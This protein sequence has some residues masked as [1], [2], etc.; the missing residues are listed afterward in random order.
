LKQAE[1]EVWKESHSNAVIA[2]INSLVKLFYD[3][4]IAL[5][6]YSGTRSQLCADRYNQSSNEIPTELRTLKLLVET[7]PTREFSAERID[8]LGET[9]LALLRKAK[10]LADERSESLSLLGSHG[11]QGELEKVMKQL[12]TELN[13]LVEAERAR[14]VSWAGEQARARL[15]LKQCIGFGAAINIFFAVALAMLFMNRISRRID[16]LV[17]NTSRL[18]KRQELL[19]F[20]GGNDEI[21][22]LDRVFHEM[23]N[24]LAEAERVKQEFLSIISH[25]LRSPLSS[26]QGTLTLLDAGAY[27]QLN[28]QGRMRVTNAEA[29]A[30]RL[31]NLINELLEIQKMSVGKL[32]MNFESTSLGP[33]LQRSIEMARVLAERKSIKLESNGIE[34]EAYVDGARI[35]QVLVNLL[36]NAIKYSPNGTTVSVKVVKEGEL[37]EFRIKDEGP[38]ISESLRET[39]FE[40]Y[41][42]GEGTEKDGTGLGLPICKAIVEEHRGQ[43]GLETELGKGSTFWFRVPK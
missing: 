1:Y 7:G 37:V 15:R 12:M 26:I 5:A 24:A 25:E 30:T 17:D 40:R 36:S 33:V 9:A 3:A 19:A 38:G 4:A 11:M 23:A 43:I 13:R 20:A 29:S 16:R 39:I 31:I 41:E 32:K 35:E 21:A 14:Q 34:G 28:D 18:A 2:E 8:E 27:G 10:R 22:H 6:A 42:Q